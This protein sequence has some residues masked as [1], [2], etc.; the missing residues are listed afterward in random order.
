MNSNDYW[1]N[2]KDIVD[3]KGW[4]LQMVGPD[5]DAD[6]PSFIYTVGLASR[7]L[8]DLLVFGL[9]RS[10]AVL[11]NTAIEKM[12]AIH[13]KD[14]YGLY[15]GLIL[16]EVA[17]MPIRMD[18]A[19]IGLAQVFATGASRHGEETGVTVSIMQLVLPDQAGRFPD[20]RACERRM[21]FIQDMPAMKMRLDAL[22]PSVPREGH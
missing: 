6:I 2:I 4:A 1:Q 14:P 20:D 11:V 22:K 10:S 15:S 13:G 21:V 12:I 18:L 17:N 7:G 5:H 19:P 8:P 9:P 16:D 3:K